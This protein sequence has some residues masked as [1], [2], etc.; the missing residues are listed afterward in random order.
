MASKL[1]AIDSRHGSLLDQLD[2]L[3]ARV[4][5]VLSDAGRD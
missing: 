3:N 1:E 2:E 4:E 5:R